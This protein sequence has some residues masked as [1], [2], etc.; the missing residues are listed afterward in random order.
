MA[1]YIVNISSQNSN[2]TVSFQIPA[3]FSTG[4]ILS[5]QSSGMSF[6]DILFGVLSVLLAVASVI[7][8]YLQLVHMRAHKL[9]NTPDQEMLEA[10][11]MLLL[12]EVVHSADT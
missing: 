3:T 1:P 4:Q 10:R 7:L 12:S 2:G 6:Q 9:A 5:G 11:K 8:A